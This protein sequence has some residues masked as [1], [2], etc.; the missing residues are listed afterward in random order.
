MSLNVRPANARLA[1]RSQAHSPGDLS[2]NDR[3]SVVSPE[4]SKSAVQRGF[5]QGLVSY[6][7]AV[8]C[9]QPLSVS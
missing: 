3:Y 6:D 2:D 1:V 7:L 8:C 5:W 4:R 9:I